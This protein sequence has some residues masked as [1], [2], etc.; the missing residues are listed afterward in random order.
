MKVLVTGG[1]G[2][3]GSAICRQLCAL[4]HLVVAYQRGAAVQLEPYGVHIVRGD[5]CD[6]AALNQA[7]AGCDA[8]IHTAGKAGLW[9]AP[10]DYRRSNIG[11]T[12]AVI[13]VCRQQAIDTLV[14]T[15]SPSVVHSGGD[16]ENGDESLP[17]ATHL[18]A[19]YP[20]TKA[21]AEQHALAANSAALRVTA[22]RPH[23]IWGPGD[24]HLLPRLISKVRRGRL[25]LP[26][27]GKKIDT[28]YIDNAA[29]A[30]LD[31][32][33]ELQQRRRCAGKAYFITNNEPLPLGEIVQRLLA[34]AGM[35]GVRIQVVPALLAIRLGSACEIAW[36]LLRIDSEPPLTRFAAEHLATAHWFNGAAARR[37]MAYSP[38]VTIAQG[39]ERLRLAGLCIEPRK[40]LI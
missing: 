27:S 5:I 11:G 15:S 7:A 13:Q 8:V 21:I 23:L 31:A 22:L 4:K 17:V 37:D 9:G 14:H 32:L 3:L 2:F 26:G 38:T 35:P 1:G 39:L 6:L 36:R 29:R 30:H 33:F 25:L 40:C 10:E 20:A 24:P 18:S 34:A 28:T 16:I 19:P 12:E